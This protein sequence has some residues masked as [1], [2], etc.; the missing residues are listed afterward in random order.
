MYEVT[1]YMSFL[2]LAQVHV[3]DPVDHLVR[4][5]YGGLQGELALLFGFEPGLQKRISVNLNFELR[6]SKFQI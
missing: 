4:V 6:T 1:D 2:Y 5:H 3:F